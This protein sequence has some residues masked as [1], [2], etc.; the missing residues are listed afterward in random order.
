MATLIFV[1]ISH[2]TSAI[3]SFLLA[4]VMRR[5]SEQLSIILLEFRCF[6]TASPH[7]AFPQKPL[8]NPYD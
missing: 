3:E 1:S 2:V 7:G 5:A 4:G 6:K 8:D